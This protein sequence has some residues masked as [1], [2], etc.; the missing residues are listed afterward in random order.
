M[1]TE[2][3]WLFPMLFM[4]TLFAGCP[5][6]QPMS[7]GIAKIVMVLN[8]LLSAIKTRQLIRLQKPALPYRRP[9]CVCS[10]IPHLH[11]RG[12]ISPL[13][14]DLDATA[15]LA[16]CR[17]PVRSVTINTEKLSL[18]PRPTPPTPFQAGIELAKVLLK[19]KPCFTGGYFRYPKPRTHSK[20]PLDCMDSIMST[21]G[22]DVKN[23]N[24]LD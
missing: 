2:I 1:P 21:G 14:F 24:R 20:S 5:Y 12:G 6:V 11:G 8:R 10:L 13:L 3:E 18:Q 19:R 4:V 22:N 7:T 17:Q 16:H 15:I 23:K 9:N